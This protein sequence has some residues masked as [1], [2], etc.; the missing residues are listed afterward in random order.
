MSS[1]W[2]EKSVCRRLLMGWHSTLMNEWS[3]KDTNPLFDLIYNIQLT[4]MC[5]WSPST[6]LPSVWFQYR[7][8]CQTT[9]INT[10]L[11]G[12]YFSDS[13]FISI[14]HCMII[15]VYQCVT[16]NLLHTF[17]SFLSWWWNSLYYLHISF[18]THQN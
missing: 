17:I 12:M 8:V 7:A 15:C 10:S 5:M 13:C 3:Q 9:N 11:L 18:I 14:L 16:N 4:R 2:K 1:S 6:S